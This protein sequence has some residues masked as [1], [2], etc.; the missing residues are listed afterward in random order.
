MVAGQNLV[1]N[2]QSNEPDGGQRQTDSGIRVQAQ[3]VN[4]HGKED[5]T[6]PAHTDT[7]GHLV[8]GCRVALRELLAVHQIRNQDHAPGEDTHHRRHGGHHSERLHDA[9]T[10][11]QH[12][13][14][15]QQQ[16]SGQVQSISGHTILGELTQ[17]GGCRT[18]MRQTVHHTGGREN[19]GVRR[20]CRGGQHHEVHQGGCNSNA[21]QG[22]HAHEGAHGLIQLVPGGHG[23]DGHQRHSVE[24]RNAERHSINSLGQGA[25]GVLGFCHCGTDELSAHEGEQRNLEGAEEAGH[26]LGE[27][28]AT[29]GTGVVPQVAYGGGGAVG[30][31][32]AEGDHE[33]A[34]NNEGDNRDDLNDGEPELDFTEVLHRG[35]VQQQQRHDN[36]QRRNE[37]GHVG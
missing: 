25:F 23:E 6:K 22:E 14:A 32:E 18:I 36:G 8:L 33:R 17:R 31:G 19:T 27:D 35:Q 16:H 34:N 10:R 20:R 5:Q 28:T 11:V 13:Q 3:G 29:G 21:R 37:F 12:D 9:V 2:S 1:A 24:E 26:T 4:H 30:A 7:P 15:K